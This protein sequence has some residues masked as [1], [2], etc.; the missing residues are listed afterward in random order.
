[1]FDF[2]KLNLLFYAHSDFLPQGKS[3]FFFFFDRTK[4][5]TVRG[6]EDEKSG[7]EFLAFNVFSV[8]L[9]SPPIA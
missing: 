6:T 4:L 5:L 7:F 1:M 2:L 3:V 9:I 8:L